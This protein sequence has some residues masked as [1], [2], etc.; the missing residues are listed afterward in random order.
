MLKPKKSKQPK[1]V[2]ARIVSNHI[3]VST[4]LHGLIDLN[5][6]SFKVRLALLEEFFK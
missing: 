4:K 6:L 1:V 5:K 2:K 3:F